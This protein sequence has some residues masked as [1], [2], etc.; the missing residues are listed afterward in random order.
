MNAMSMEPETC[1]LVPANLTPAGSVCLG[2]DGRAK[3]NG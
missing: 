3:L 1:N 2:E